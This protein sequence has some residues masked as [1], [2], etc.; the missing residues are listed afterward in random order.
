MLRPAC[1]WEPWTCTTHRGTG[2]ASLG[3]PKQ[4]QALAPGE[5]LS[6]L[7]KQEWSRGQHITCH[8]LVARWWLLGN[9]TAASD[10]HSLEADAAKGCPAPWIVQWA[11][12]RVGD[13]CPPDVVLELCIGDFSFIARLPYQSFYPQHIR[14]AMGR[15]ADS[16]RLALACAG[17]HSSIFPPPPP[18]PLW[19]INGNFFPGPWV[20]G[21]HAF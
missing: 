20:C 17:D 15:W 19:L 5:D 7:P 18:P 4:V 8:S 10:L 21:G 9:P 14:S 11:A 3:C 6:W 1:C 12:E 2:R 16:C 13:P